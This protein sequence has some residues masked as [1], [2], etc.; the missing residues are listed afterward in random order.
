[1]DEFEL[2]GRFY[3]DVP[4]TDAAARERALARLRVARRSRMPRRSAILAAAVGVVSALAVVVLQV[5]SP[6]A[7]ATELR[8]LAA[9]AGTRE[10]AAGTRPVV[11]EAG[12]VLDAITGQG[13]EAAD[14]F[15]ILVDAQVERWRSR[16]GEVLQIRRVVDARFRSPAD[17]LVWETMGRPLPVP[18]RGETQRTE[19]A[20]GEIPFPDL[21]ELPLEPE[22]LLEMIRSG[23]TEERLRTDEQ[24][25]LALS[26]L[27]V[28]GDATAEL[29][30][31]LFEAAASL[32]S[33]ELLGERTDPLGRVGVGLGVGPADRRVVVTVDPDTSELLAVEQRH[34]SG[35]QALE[36]WQA[37]TAWTT[38][39]QM[40][41]QP[42]GVD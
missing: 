34:G 32:G 20:P 39:D 31:T 17:R 16:S 9:I 5:S 19:I 36:S 24:T 30:R 13:I 12:E 25:L 21:A 42:R 3:G 11:Y 4:V 35:A 22:A 37:Y 6:S 10:L 23:W 40:G 41:D 14:G 26:E 18:E 1:M 7:A 38:V 2:V 29:R 15:V 8:R 33:V 28:R 27:L